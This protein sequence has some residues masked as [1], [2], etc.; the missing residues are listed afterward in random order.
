M[1]KVNSDVTTTMFHS[2]FIVNLEYISYLFIPFSS[3]STVGFEQVNISWI[4]LNQF[5]NVEIAYCCKY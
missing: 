3:V 4:P 5:I 1:L 2:V